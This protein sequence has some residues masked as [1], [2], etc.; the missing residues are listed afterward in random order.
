MVLSCKDF[1]DGGCKLFSSDFDENLS[2]IF[3]LL[4]FDN[5]GWVTK[6]DIRIVLSHVPLA[7]MLSGS[8]GAKKK[9]GQ[10]T[11]SGGGAYYGL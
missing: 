10:Y 1:V 3:R 11:T 4:D 5:D 8:K 2:F 6:E 7:H 9:E